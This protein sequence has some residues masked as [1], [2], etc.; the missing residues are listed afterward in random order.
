MNAEKFM[1]DIMAAFAQADLRPLMAALDDNVLWKSA[2]GSGGPAQSQVSYRGRLAA[3]ETLSNMA[4]DYTFM[5]VTPTEVM[6]TGDIVWGIYE[7]VVRHN[8]APLAGSGQAGNAN[9]VQ[10]DMAIRWRLKDGKIVEHQAFYHT[11]AL[12]GM[13]SSVLR[14]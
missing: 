6:A 12:L 7:M 3:V 14:T 9:A 5:R 13:I 2:N 10:F 8:R 11:A 1:R 4:R